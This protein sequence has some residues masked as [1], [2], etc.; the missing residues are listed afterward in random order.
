[1]SQSTQHYQCAGYPLA[2]RARPVSALSH[3]WERGRLARLVSS[4]CVSAPEPDSIER[5]QL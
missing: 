2:G 5:A 3:H 1:M 4:L